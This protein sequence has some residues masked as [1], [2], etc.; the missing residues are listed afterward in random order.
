MYSTDPTQETSMCY[1]DYAGY[2]RDSPGNMSYRSYRWYRSTVYLPCMSDLDDQVSLGID[3]LVELCI[4]Y[5]CLLI[6]VFIYSVLFVPKSHPA[7]CVCVCVCF[8]F[9][10]R[11]GGRVIFLVVRPLL[12]TGM[13]RFRRG[14][15]PAV[16]SRLGISTAAGSVVRPSRAPLLCSLSCAHRTG[17]TSEWALS[18]LPAADV[19]IIQPL[20]LISKSIDE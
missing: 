1:I 20:R 18:Y 14:N 10:R 17:A 9:F 5:M 13:L 2:H 7:V 8:F 15:T 6:G 12:Y 11:C 3:Y 19:N 4:G 16:A